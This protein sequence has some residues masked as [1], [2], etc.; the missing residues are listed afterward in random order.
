MN[1]NGE[2]RGKGET[3]DRQQCGR[4]YE[5]E[6]ARRADLLVDSQTITRSQSATE[7]IGSP[8]HLGSLSDSIACS[9]LCTTTK[10]STTG[11]VKTAYRPRFAGKEFRPI[12][13]IIAI[14]VENTP[15]LTCVKE[16]RLGTALIAGTWEGKNAGK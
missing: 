3:H 2:K 9:I 4:K 6:L 11:K 14:N 8:F 12:L 13:S 15:C 1:S 10:A 5:R 16:P 7:N